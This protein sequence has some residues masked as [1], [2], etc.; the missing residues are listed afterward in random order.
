MELQLPTGEIGPREEPEQFPTWFVVNDCGW[1]P[2]EHEE[3]LRKAA[4]GC[5][6]RDWNRE[7]REAALQEKEEHERSMEEWKAQ[8]EG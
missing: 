2:E 1:T 5:N 6:Y 4:Q 3:M 7:I 8:V